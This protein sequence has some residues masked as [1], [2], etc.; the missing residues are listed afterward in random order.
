MAY[1]RSNGRLS[2]GLSGRWGSASVD[3]RYQLGGIEDLG[4]G[5]QVNGDPIL[6]LIAQ[7]NRFAGKTVAPGFR[8]KPTVYLHGALP[9]APELSDKAAS[10][11]WLLMGQRYS[12]VPDDQFSQSKNAWVNSFNAGSIADTKA[13]V[14]S[15][16]N[17]ITITIA[18]FGDK[19]GLA[20][21]AYGITERDTKFTPSLTPTTAI[22]AVGAVGL[23][24]V[25]ALRRKGKR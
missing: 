8:C 14:Q 1:L 21:A 15:N 9:M 6:A 18:Q 4:L 25:L 22:F 20:P 24:L 17:E 13:W 5:P 7:L 16:L 2:T 23:G 10:T 19:L 11:A 12:C 3:A